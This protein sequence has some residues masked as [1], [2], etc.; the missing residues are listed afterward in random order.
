MWFLVYSLSDVFRVGHWL[1]FE[2]VT[3]EDF[4][5][6]TLNLALR[7]QLKFLQVPQLPW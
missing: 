7:F 4:V 3:L 2:S 5:G 6:F 1:E